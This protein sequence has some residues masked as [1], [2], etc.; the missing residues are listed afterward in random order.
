MAVV[1]YSLAQVGG[2]LSITWPAITT[3]A[4]PPL[5]SGDS[6]AP[7]AAGGESDKTVTITGTATTFALQGSND[8]VNWFT[9]HNLDNA[10][11]PITAAGMFL[12]KENPLYIRPLL[13]TGS[14]VTVI[15]SLI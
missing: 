9:L 11:T 5:A 7:V 6:G 14:G 12:I 3:P 1:P 13:T 15:L 8:L 10:D 4:T 2:A